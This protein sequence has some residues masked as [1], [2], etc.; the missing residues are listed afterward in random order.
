MNL[1]PEYE[2]SPIVKEPWSDDGCPNCKFKEGYVKDRIEYAEL[3]TRA[4][5]KRE[6]ELISVEFPIRESDEFDEGRRSMKREVL[7]ILK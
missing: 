2:N 5:L 1:P 3:Q 6:I 7:D 4:N